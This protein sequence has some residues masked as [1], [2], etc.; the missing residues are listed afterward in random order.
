[1]VTESR[2]R[3]GDAIEFRL[4]T[5]GTLFNDE[6]LRFLAEQR[7]YFTLSLDG[8]GAQQDRLRH[9]P[10]GNGSFEMISPHLEKI[11]SL[12]PYTVVVSVIAPETVNDL[13][14]GVQE[15]Y[16]PASVTSCRHST[17]QASGVRS[18]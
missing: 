5:N 11:L 10:N 9:L 18:I 6:I 17:I 1:M 13:A 14:D 15:L 2:R 16:R 8:G 3:Y 7:I 12:N 4:S